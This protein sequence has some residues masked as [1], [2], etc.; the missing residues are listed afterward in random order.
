MA[1]KDVGVRLN[2]AR[3]IPD[4]IPAG[5]YHVTFARVLDGVLGFTTGI[6]E[7]RVM[8]Q[9][10]LDKKFPQ[11]TYFLAWTGEWRTDLFALTPKDAKRLHGTF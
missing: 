10:L 9:E 1:K 2:Q 6:G 8:L 11:A 5:A 4:D 3:T 7:K